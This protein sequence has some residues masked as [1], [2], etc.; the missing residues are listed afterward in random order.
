MAAITDAFALLGLTRSAHVDEGELR[1]RFLQASRLAHPDL[2]GGA[3]AATEQ[4]SAAL[5]EAHRVLRD[6]ALRAEHLIALLGGPSAQEEGATPAGLLQEQMEL[7]EQAD[8][9]R[10]AQDLGRLAALREQLSA[11]CQ[12]DVDAALL[13]LSQALTSAEP[14]ALARSARL[15]LNA[16]RYRRS[17]LSQLP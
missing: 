4:A 6:P 11:A 16:A 3:D 12:A 13:H 5:N 2:A 8:E 15:R 7:R 14:S 9:A 17:L 10:A 1:R